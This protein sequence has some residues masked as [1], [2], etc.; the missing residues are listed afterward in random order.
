MTA[1]SIYGKKTLKIFFSE[2]KRL[3]I[4]KLGMRHRLLDYY[5]I[6]L[7]NDTGFTLIY[8]TA[9]SNLVPFVFLSE[10]AEAVDQAVDFQET[11]E[12]CEVKVGTYSQINEYM[13][14]YDNQRSRS[15]I[16]L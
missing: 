10:S 11:I 6:C 9:R 16:D 2:F 3:M 15:F 5:Q 7:N 4:L 8:F 12:A 14:I 13:M 1:M